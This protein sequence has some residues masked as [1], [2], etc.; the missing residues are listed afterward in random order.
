[1]SGNRAR[2]TSSCT[3]FLLQSDERW[4]L[5]KLMGTGVAMIEHHYG[6]LLVPHADRSQRIL[7]AVRSE[8]DANWT[9]SRPPMNRPPQ[10]FRVTTPKTS[11][12]L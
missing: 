11:E 12:A 5:S 7:D 2:D 8:M 4:L 3:W 9:Q 1:M 10:R 6:H